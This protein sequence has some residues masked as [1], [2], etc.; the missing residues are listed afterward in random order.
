MTDSTVTHTLFQ[1]STSGALVAGIFS[2]AV[3]CRTLLDHGDFG[4]GTFAKLDGEMVVLEGKI[5]Q[6][7]SDGSVSLASADEEA[8]FAVVTQFSADVDAADQALPTLDALTKRCDDARPSNN[9]FYAYR[10]DGKF[11]MLRA[12]AVSPPDNDE[13][14]VDAAKRQTEFKFSNISGTLVGLWSPGFSSAFSVPGYHFHFIS[15]DRKHG[16]HLLI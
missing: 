7:R 2:G 5:Y 10:V 1:V 14:L 15:D 6:V 12:R 16:G 9:I 4:V 8:P 11:D 13:R 3:S